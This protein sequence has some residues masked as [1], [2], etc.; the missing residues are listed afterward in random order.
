MSSSS[1]LTEEQLRRIEENRRR[2]LEIKAARENAAAQDQQKKIDAEQQRRIEENRRR[3][4][5]LKA[6]REKASGQPPSKIFKPNQPSPTTPRAA[7]YP[8]T[9]STSGQSPLVSSG[10]NNQYSKSATQTQNAQVFGEKPVLGKCV[11]N[12]RTTFHV[13]M[14]YHAKAIDIFKTINSRKY[15]EQ[16]ILDLNST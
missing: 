2:A 16:Y 12:D 3:A 4:L 5:E 14:G 7:T 15:G 9:G 10:A 1:T 11:L 6:A 13:D 8:P